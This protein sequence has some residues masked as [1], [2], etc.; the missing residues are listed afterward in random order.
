MFKR[1]LAVISVLIA[2]LTVFVSPAGAEE[3]SVLYHATV[4]TAYGLNSSSAVYP[5]PDVQKPDQTTERL[6]LLK[7]GAA[8]DIIDVLPNYVEI[9]YGHG[10]GFVLRKRIENVKTLDPVS[11]PRYGTTVSRYYAELDRD[12]PVKSAASADSE[13]LITL[14]A[15]A[16]LGFIDIVDGWAQLIFHRQYAY[17]NTEYLSSIA[18]VAPVEQAGNSDTPIAVFNSFYN[19]ADNEM[20]LNRIQNLIVGCMRMDR[21]MA[22]GES[23][24]FNGTVGPFNP[25]NGYLTSWG[26][27]EGELVPSSGGGSCQ[28]SSTLYNVVLQLTGLTVLA[29]APHGL[30]GAAYLPHGVDATSGGLNFI[31]RNDYD[32]PIRIF[33]HVQDGSL[34]VAIYKESS[35]L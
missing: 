1:I 11:T 8:I 24:D 26:L 16:Y 32:F 22:P 12:T 19:I 10:T 5:S 20:N 14:G 4:T 34:F 13:T 7:A 29:R 30:D 18:M 6:G 28:V 2:V 3:K 33:S 15:G 9:L 31:F 21:V 35:V 17:V 25:R 23:L 27:F